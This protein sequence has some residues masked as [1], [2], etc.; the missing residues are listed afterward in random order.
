[1]LKKYI[2]TISQLNNFEKTDIL[3]NKFTIEQYGKMQIIYAPHNEYINKS[4]KILIVGICPGWTQTQIAY[5]NVNIRM[6][7]NCG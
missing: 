2:E 7:K 3:C 6:S 5:I 4:A 1:M